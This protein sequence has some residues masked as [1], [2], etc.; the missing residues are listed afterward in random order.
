MG[1][2][3]NPGSL[4]LSFLLFFLQFLLQPAVSGEDNWKGQHDAFSAGGV[5]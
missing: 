5:N 1:P 4:V 2:S 3:G